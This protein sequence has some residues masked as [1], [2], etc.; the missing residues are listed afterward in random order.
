MQALPDVEMVDAASQVGEFL[1][2][3][4]ATTLDER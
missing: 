1:D 2:L 4:Q 3:E